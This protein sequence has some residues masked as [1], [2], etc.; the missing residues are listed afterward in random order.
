MELETSA[1]RKAMSRIIWGGCLALV[2]ME[3]TGGAPCVDFYRALGATEFQFG[4]IGAVPLLMLL[5][6]FMSAIWSIRL[7]RRKYIWISMTI[8]HRLLLLPLAFLPW[9]F[10]AA[11]PTVL[12]WGVIGI[13]SCS[14]L[15]ANAAVPMWF[16][17]MGDLLPHDTLNAF[18][19]RRRRWMALTHGGVMLLSA[20][21][22]WRLREV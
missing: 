19:A 18:W 21:F 5:L 22:F 6:Q 17:W 13:L 16:A 2:F 1:L 14:Q 3:F 12:V 11:S 4:V 15:L 8:L 7:R 10:P 9:W 20:L